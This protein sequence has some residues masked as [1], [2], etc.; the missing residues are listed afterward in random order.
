MELPLP[1]LPLS[2]LSFESSYLLSIHSWDSTIYNRHLSHH[3]VPFALTITQVQH[4]RMLMT[5]KSWSTHQLP[6][7]ALTTAFIYLSHC[8]VQREKKWKNVSN[9]P[10][11]SLHLQCS[12]VR[13]S[14]C[15]S[16]SN[17]WSYR[18]T[19]SISLL[20]YNIAVLFHFHG[21][22][23]TSNN[24]QDW[25]LLHTSGILKSGQNLT[26]TWKRR[27]TSLDLEQ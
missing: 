10:I 21:G 16:R 27:T 9:S 4:L 22:S 8:E 15:R 3:P 14:F 7:A 2:L 25:I 26:F 13:L 20:C 12:N 11:S 1:Q 24:V 23:E 18:E 6:Q 17:S 19:A 5:D